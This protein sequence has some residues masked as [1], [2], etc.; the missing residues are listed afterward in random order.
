MIYGT[1]DKRNHGKDTE[2]NEYHQLMLRM[3][4]SAITA[5]VGNP[6][7]IN[8]QSSGDDTSKDDASEDDVSEDNASEDDIK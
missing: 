5:H 6:F 2:D 1:N 4:F 7:G 8:D 3:Y